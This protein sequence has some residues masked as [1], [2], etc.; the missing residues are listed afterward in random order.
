MGVLEKVVG[1]FIL[2]MENFGML[3]WFLY[4]VE[5]G[6]CVGSIYFV[7]SIFSVSLSFCLVVF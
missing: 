1:G 6:L 5:C 7:L 3:W 4:R 2:G